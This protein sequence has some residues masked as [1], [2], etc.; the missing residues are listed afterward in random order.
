VDGF[1]P[2]LPPNSNVTINS[3]AQEDYRI[4]RA[5]RP[6]LPNVRDFEKHHRRSPTITLGNFAVIR[7]ARDDILF[8]AAH[9]CG[10]RKASNIA[11]CLGPA[12]KKTSLQIGHS[13][14]QWRRGQ[15]ILEACSWNL[16]S[17]WWTY[18]SFVNRSADKRDI[19]ENAS[20]VHPSPTLT[21]KADFILPIRAFEG[22]GNAGSKGSIRKNRVGQ[23]L[24][25]HVADIET[26]APTVT[27]WTAI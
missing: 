4:G 27:R 7:F 24:L 21:P 9:T 16:A 14:S 6:A 19:D 17:K 18:G 22:F 3:F 12:L 8:R 25:D 26:Q 10:S 1:P 13:R 20:D 2:A 11:I 23:S 15:R 5:F